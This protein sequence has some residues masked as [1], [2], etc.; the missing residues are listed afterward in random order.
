MLWSRI[1]GRLPGRS[2]NEIKNHWES[3]HIKRK[4]LSRGIDPQSRR[5]IQPFHSDGSSSR[6]DR[7]PS[8][9]ISMVDSF[10]SERCI[11]TGNFDLA[12]SNGNFD[13]AASN[14]ERH[15]IEPFHRDDRSPSQE[16]SMVDF[17]QSERGIVTGN[18]DLAASNIERHTIQPFHR[19]D[20]S[21]CQEIS[22]VDFFQSE[23][24]IVTSNFDLA[25]SNGTSGSEETSDVNLE[26]TLGLQSSASRANKSQ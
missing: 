11:V 4:L 2:D 7:S 6:D 25:A 3:T 10:Q 26:L 18:F 12:A 9:E 15:T 23:P 5:T 19:D 22:I 24:C 16:I 1:A 14:I 13:L 21:P 17:F 8:Q 20:R